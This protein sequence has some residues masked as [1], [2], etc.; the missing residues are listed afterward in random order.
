MRAMA[1]FFQEKAWKALPGL[2]VSVSKWTG[3][4]CAA[5]V[6]PGAFGIGFAANL[7]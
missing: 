2:Q 7:S 6:T 1:R 4:T 3:S 5:G